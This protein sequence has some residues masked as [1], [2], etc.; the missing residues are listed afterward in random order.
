MIEQALEIITKH[1]AVSDPYK[2]PEIEERINEYIM[3]NIVEKEDDW[4]Q[5]KFCDKQ[6]KG[7]NF[8]E[9]HIASKHEN[10]VEEEKKRFLFDQ[11]K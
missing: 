9:K 8:V 11:T 1:K 3:W 10:C 2:N 6:F 5:C 7:Q 4:Y